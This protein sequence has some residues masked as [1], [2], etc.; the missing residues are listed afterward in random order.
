MVGSGSFQIPT[1][2]MCHPPT[3]HS[4]FELKQLLLHGG[5]NVP[6]TT[7]CSGHLLFNL[8]IFSVRPFFRWVRKCHSFHNFYIL[9]NFPHF[10]GLFIFIYTGSGLL[11]L[12]LL[13]I[14]SQ[15]NNATKLIYENN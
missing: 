1:T 6:A 4:P 12:F 5:Q 2:K 15:R 7:P 14:W 11:S 8:H 13:L 9:R 3:L 10:C